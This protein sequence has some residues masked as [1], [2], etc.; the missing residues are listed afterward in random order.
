MGCGVDI[1]H[2]T[3][4][5]CDRERCWTYV[6][7][8]RP[9]K[10]GLV[11]RP[12]KSGFV[13]APGFGDGQVSSA[14]PGAM[15]VVSPGAVISAVVAPTLDSPGMETPEAELS[16]FVYPDAGPGSRSGY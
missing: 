16:P 14:S 3:R 11:R 8:G 9:E 5:N 6:F 10:G 15:M 13:G 4:F 12:K 1:C 2:S 7:I